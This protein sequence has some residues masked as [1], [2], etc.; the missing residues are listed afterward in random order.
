MGGGCNGARPVA[1]ARA[2]CAMVASLSFVQAYRKLEEGG[3]QS[4]LLLCWLVIMTL[5]WERD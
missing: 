4:R 3:L 5:N 1:S 2:L